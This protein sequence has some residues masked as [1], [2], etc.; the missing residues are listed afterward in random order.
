MDQEDD[1]E[2]DWENIEIPDIQINQH[3]KI[4]NKERE[5]RLLEERRKMEEADLILANDL[6]GKETIKNNKNFKPII[7][8]KN[9]KQSE[10]KKVIEMRRKNIIEKQKKESQKLNEL[11]IKHKKQIEIFGEANR[12]EY[13]ELYGN[14]ENKY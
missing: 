8:C 7:I 1:L 2:E 4:K 12:D 14:I 5:E 3:E 13:E 6:F 10:L 9:E 11:K